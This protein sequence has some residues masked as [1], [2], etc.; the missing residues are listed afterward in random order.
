MTGKNSA[1]GL[2]CTPVRYL[3]L[4]EV[5]SYPGEGDP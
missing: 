1:V 4:D 3:F 2:L 5:D